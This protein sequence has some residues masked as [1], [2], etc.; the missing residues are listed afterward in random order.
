MR[1]C[2]ARRTGSLCWLAMSTNGSQPK[3]IGSDVTPAIILM[4]KSDCS[5]TGATRIF[6]PGPNCVWPPFT[7]SPWPKL[8]PHFRTGRLPLSFSKAL[9]ILIGSRAAATRPKRRAEGVGGAR[10]GD[11]KFYFKIDGAFSS[12]AAP[13]NREGPRLRLRRRR[14]TAAKAPISQGEQLEPEGS[15]LLGHSS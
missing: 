3:S 8:Q 1:R 13:R 6:L 7:V 9:P 10:A 12:S 5:S 2:R 15:R 4:T 14:S 11:R